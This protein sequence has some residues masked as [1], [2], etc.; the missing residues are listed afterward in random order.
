MSN[1]KK[2]PHSRAHIS[3]FSHDSSDLKSSAC[4]WDNF[5]SHQRGSILGSTP[6]GLS[7]E[8]RQFS[9][10]RLNYFYTLVSHHVWNMFGING[11]SGSGELF[12]LFSPSFVLC[13]FLLFG[14][15]WPP[16]CPKGTVLPI[17]SVGMCHFSGKSSQ[18]FKSWIWKINGPVWEF[19][20]ICVLW[21]V[22]HKCNFQSSTEATYIL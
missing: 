7:L 21:R 12:I 16:T 6:M 5:H 2:F 14:F 15:L 17:P 13:L 3:A 1:A 19:D 11:K 8:P 22:K 9:M 4:S 10:V 20:Q 18:S